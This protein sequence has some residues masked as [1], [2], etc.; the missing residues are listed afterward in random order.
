LNINSHKEY[1]K[2]LKEENINLP[3]NPSVIYKKEWISFSEYLNSNN[4]SNSKK[5]FITYE[6][7]EKIILNKGFKSLNQL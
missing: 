2:W 1:L 7:C 3:T 6:E 5:E 4:I